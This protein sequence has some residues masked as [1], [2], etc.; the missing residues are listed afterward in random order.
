MELGN[1]TQTEFDAHLAHNTLRL[2]FVGMSNAGKSYRARAL[3]QDAGFKW[4]HVDGEIQHTL[5]IG[6]MDEISAWLGYPDS[7]TYPE[8]ERQYLAAENLNTKLDTHDTDSK[9]LVFDTTGSVIYLPADTIRWL[10]ESCLMVNL[11]VS[12]DKM[13]AMMRKFF[14]EPKPLIWSGFFV[15]V[16]GE[17]EHET[18]SRCYPLLLHDR[19]A[20]YAALG[21]ITIDA[22]SLYDTS[23]QET[24]AVI[25]SHL[26]KG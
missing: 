9:N 1:L 26:A 2:A 3:A 12:E 15:P 22:D 7:Q 24:L 16:E 4:H 18:L 8:R 14:D 10:K 5:G 17:S 11:A 19:L 6:S 25:R 23:G 20:Q 13:D 21:H